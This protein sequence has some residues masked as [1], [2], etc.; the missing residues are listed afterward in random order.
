M[1]IRSKNWNRKIWTGR[2]ANRAELSKGFISQLERNLTSS[3]ATLIGYSSCLGTIDRILCRRVRWTDRLSQR[4]QMIFVKGHRTSA[5][6]LNGSFNLKRIW[7]NQSCLHW[8]PE[9]NLLR[10]PHEEELAMF[11]MDGSIQI[12]GRKVHTA[13]KE[14]FTDLPIQTLYKQQTNKRCKDYMV[15]TLPSFF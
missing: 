6:P 3:I 13:K 14:S 9:A 5:T 12:H 4:P 1:E 7:W 10:R 15:T 11:C 2:I 8:K